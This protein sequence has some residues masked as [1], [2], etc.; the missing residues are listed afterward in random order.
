VMI[1]CTAPDADPARATC[2][3]DAGN[4]WEALPV[5]DTPGEGG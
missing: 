2:E 1:R 3:I 5:V 4:G